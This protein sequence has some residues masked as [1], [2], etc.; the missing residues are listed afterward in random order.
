LDNLVALR[1]LCHVLD[2]RSV[3]ERPAWARTRGLMVKRG[4][5]PADKPL[6][7]ATGARVYLHPTESRYLTSQEHRRRSA[8]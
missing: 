8:A 4:D 5:T 7:L 2:S 1:P 6:T 3:H